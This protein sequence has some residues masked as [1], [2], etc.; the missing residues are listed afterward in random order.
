MT[1]LEVRQDIIPLC[2]GE[3]IAQ[4]DNSKEDPFDWSHAV[5]FD[6]SYG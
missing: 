3:G 4:D 1:W 5:S 2:L 6:D